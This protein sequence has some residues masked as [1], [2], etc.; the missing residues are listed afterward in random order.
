[1]PATAGHALPYPAATD[2]ADVPSD[3]QKLAAAVDTALLPTDTVVVAATRIIKNLL[4][5]GDANPAFQLNGNGAMFWGAGGANATDVNL[6]RITS[7]FTGLGLTGSFRATSAVYAWYTDA[8]RFTAM[9]ATGSG[10]AAYYWGADLAVFAYRPAAGAFLRVAPVLEVAGNLRVD[11]SGGGNSLLFGS[12]N[13]T[14]MWK[15]S[16]ANIQVKDYLHVNQA[17]YSSDGQVNQ[18]V[19]LGGDGSGRACVFW[20]TALDTS[21]L[22]V[23]AGGLGTNNWYVGGALCLQ[24]AV[25]GSVGGAQPYKFPVYN[26]NKTF[27]GYCPIYTS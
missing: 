1:M 25:S 10:E 8:A 15:S 9:G 3:M 4:L 6:Q 16:S 14:M 2:P 23:E 19:A 21:I 26:Q 7:P 17:I 24:S 27:L 13:T 11:Q 20:G 12:D 5:A 18:Q 22:R